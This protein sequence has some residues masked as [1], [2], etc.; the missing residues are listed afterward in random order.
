M[1][2]RMVCSSSQSQTAKEIHSFPL[3]CSSLSQRQFCPILKR[4]ADQLFTESTLS[5]SL[6]QM[7]FCPIMNWGADQL[8]SFYSLRLLA[9]PEAVSSHTESRSRWAV[10]SI[11]F[12]LL[13]VPEAVLSHIES[14]SRWDGQIKFSTAPRCPR[15]SLVPY[16]NE[17]N[18]FHPVLALLGTG[19]PMFPPSNG[20]ITV[21]ALANAKVIRLYFDLKTC[22]TVANSCNGLKQLW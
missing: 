10:Q 6:S 16:Q 1:G 5:S 18:Q 12:E 15:G 2:P 17:E 11:N 14:R 21:A 8:G 4:G 13:A 22:Q 3:S 7:Q 9:V 20:N 19:A